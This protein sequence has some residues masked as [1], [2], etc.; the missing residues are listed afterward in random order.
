MESEVTQ[1]RSAEVFP[2]LS[3]LKT[4][5]TPHRREVN[6]LSLGYLPNISSSEVKAALRGSNRYVIIF[7]TEPANWAKPGSGFPL[8]YMTNKA[9]VK[10][11]STCS[12][13][14]RMLLWG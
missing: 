5:N 13:F 11:R 4:K 1:S 7:C 12:N 9:L 3:V 6:I 14:Y 2:R 8:Q 10:F